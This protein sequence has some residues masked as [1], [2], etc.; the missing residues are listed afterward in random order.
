MHDTS[1]VQADLSVACLPDALL[2][3][4]ATE[5][6]H[7]CLVLQLI[8]PPAHPGSAVLSL[9]K[10]PGTIGSHSPLPSPQFAIPSHMRPLTFPACLTLTR[11]DFTCWS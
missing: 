3:K 2:G 5:Y 1:E 9:P 8:T 11:S 4:P 6:S 10:V 7:G